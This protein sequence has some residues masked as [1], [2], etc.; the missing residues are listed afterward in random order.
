[1]P[2]PTPPVRGLARPAGPLTRV[3]T[4]EEGRI[5]PTKVPPGVRCLCNGWHAESAPE[6]A[7]KVQVRASGTVT[8]ALKLTQQP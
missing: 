3:S 6:D 5:R 4:D 1:M 8:I 7:A 2:K